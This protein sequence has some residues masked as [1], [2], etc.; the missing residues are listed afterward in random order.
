MLRRFRLAIAILPVLCLLTLVNAEAQT[1]VALPYTMTTIGGL[2]PMSAS[3][4]TQCPNLPAGVKSTDA[5]GD[6]CLAVNGV[7]GAGGRGG[8]QVDS[9]GNI[10]VADDVNK[11]AH[12]INPTTGIMTLLAGGGSVCAGRVD[13]FGD[14]CLAAT[15]TSFS[16]VSALRGIGIDPYG[17][18][19]LAGYNTN[20]IHVVCRTA[21]PLCAPANIGY[22]ELAAGCVASSTSA[23]SA[24]A[25]L[26]N[27]PGIST[28]VACST[29]LGEV[30]TARGATADVY[31][32]VYYADTA[33][34]RWRVVLGPLTSS[35]FAGNNP[36]WSALE[37]NSSWYD[38]STK[39]LTAGYVY[40]VG[41]L[42]TSSTNQTA[43]G[44]QTNCNGGGTA[45]D[46][47]GDGCLFTSSYIA[48][49]TS[50]S[51]GIG[52]DAAGNMIF[53]DAGR[54][55]RVFYVSDGTNFANTGSAG[56][57]A[58]QAMKNAITV[59]NSGYTGWSGSP[60]TGFM[61][62]LAGGGST[63][64]SATPTLGN[65]TAALDTGTLKMTVSPQ[66]NIYIGDTTPRVL[67]FDI[68]SG[69]IRTLLT[70]GTTVTQ[71]NYCNGGSSGQKSLS[72]YS[73]GC[74]VSA[75][76][77]SYAPFAN[78]NG[79][80]VA[81]DGQGNLYMHDTTG[82]MLIRKVLAQGLAEQTLGTPLI[83][84]F[85]T[86]F[87][88]ASSS[89][90]TV[91]ESTNGNLSYGTPSC[92]LHADDSVDCN[93][94]VTAT[95]SAAGLR[96][97]A[98]TVANASAA[99]G[100]GEAITI[101][102][103]G[104]VTGSILVVDNASVGGSGIPPTANAILTGMTPSSVAVDGAGNV[105]TASGPDLSESIGGTTYPLSPALTFTPSQIAVDQ[106]GNAFAVN[107][108]TST[109]TELQVTTA[110]TPS[111]YTAT[112]ISYSNGSTPAPVAI[113]VDQA[114]NLY[115]ADA[116]TETIYRLSMVANTL[117][118]Q[119]TV[120][121]GFSNVV[122][123]SVDPAG[124]V[125]V[126]DK[127]AGKVYELTPAI[128]LGQYGYSQSTKLSGVTP[129]ALAV[130]PAGDVYVQDDSSLSVIEVAVSGPSTGVTVL[131]GLIS[132][133][134][135]AVDGLGNVYSA[136]E[137]NTSIT[138]VVRGNFAENFGTS[139]TTDF[140]ATLTNVG[141]QASTG[142]NTST[143]NTTNFTVTG[144]G[145]PACTVSSNVLGAM[146]AGQACTLSAELTG[147][148]STTVND[149]ITF[150]PSTSTAGELTLTGTLLGES[151]PTTP[152]IS[153]P[154]G[155]QIFGASP[156]VSF[157]ITV[158]A[159]TAPSA[160]TG[161]VNVYVDSTTA[162]TQYSLTAATSTS[163]A[164]TVNLSGLSAGSH[165]IAVVYPTT[166]A[167]TGSGSSSTT[168]PFSIAQAGTSVSW[169]PSATTQQVSSAI[170]TG[171]LNATV[172]PSI[173]G[174]FVYTATPSGGSAITIDASSYLPIGTYSLGVTFYPIDSVDY[175]SATASVASYTVTQATATAAVGASTNVVAADGTGNYTSLSTALAAL[176]V[177]GGTLYLKPGIYTGQNAISYPNVYLRGLGGDPTKVILTAED[178]AFSAPFVYPGSG[179]GNA[180]ASGDQ[181]SSTLDVSKSLYMGTTLG[182]TQFTPNN[183]FAEYLTIQ[184]TYN[185]DATTATTYNTTS[186]TCANSGPSQTLQAVYNSG[187]QC[188]SQALALWIESDQAI[189]NNVNLIS[190]QDTLY[191]GSQGCGTFCT[192]ARQY[193][194]RGMITGDVDYVFGDAAMVFDHT[195]FF[196]TW[197]GA[198][199]GENTIEAQDKRFQ[200]SS[201]SDYLSGYICNGCTLMSQST[202]MTN[203]YYG[204]PYSANNST[205]YSTWIMLN[206]FVDQVNPAGWIEFTPGTTNYL[207]S[208]TYA[209]YNTQTFTDPTPGT[210][211]YPATLFGGTVTPTG[212]NIGAGVTGTRETTSTDPG[213]L[214]ASNAIRTSTDGGSKRA[215]Y[216]S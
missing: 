80:G 28:G 110:G 183:F 200:T 174:D 41:G 81:V 145:A 201:S 7:F 1:P 93:V 65:N 126:A 150:L 102:L 11:V 159:S 98:M 175:A 155:A 173:A 95:P 84:T 48:G 97:A 149:F 168:T 207:P 55:L 89:T 190:Q 169:A 120:A 64:I 151:Y 184:N 204:R 37:K 88:S 125:Y 94:T 9:F 67:F 66:G 76:A 117:Q 106:T 112:E 91:T 118:K 216:Y 167:F 62:M 119:T 27:K 72:A 156:E 5:Y 185:T 181:G 213:T 180:N 87:L 83:Q 108:G 115:V 189:L 172:T 166:G 179:A 71:G 130:D 153:A 82:T 194:W 116:T 105:Y 137:N 13:E 30:D 43:A 154:S 107:S 34:E 212:G 16:A 163:S 210:A 124:N 209:E 142:Q 54:G 206:S 61:Y 51:Q 25:G 10:F 4:G 128:V 100:S 199:T 178:G 160:P 134:G 171:P 38:G 197:H 52:V 188:N 33:S 111:T 147:S 17:N 26:D 121:S 12:M 18:V 92:T 32:N 49:S 132:P 86:H 68:N 123:L 136:D 187:K 162:F 138:R 215:Q 129:V 59:N 143:S 191:A 8:V 146:S 3:S 133:T 161:S 186:G 140:I 205:T 203:L 36:L 148:G 58:G 42:V 192:V 141:N 96:S 131:S 45:T 21:S 104:T 79:L 20:L 29:S 77:T 2:A 46:A 113:A 164:A 75:S 101:G 22:M 39:F 24:G 214:E 176:P 47:W 73:D 196:T 109:I 85:Q 53:T 15:Q 198:A 114:G 157:T 90:S 195:N 78:S 165:T 211:G 122:S 152:T 202:G 44:S 99:S 63:G 127:G 182:S 40:T 60:V 139:E 70:P 6:G 57:I 144:G 14:G 208:A 103:G 135:L 170:G 50:Y 23:G 158:T 74:P 177:T 69:Y 56:Y 193:M 35:Y 31:G 19:L